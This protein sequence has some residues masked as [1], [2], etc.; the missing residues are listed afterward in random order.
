MEKT[1]KRKIDI[2]RILGVLFI[3][4]GLTIMAVDFGTRFLDRRSQQNE[5]QDF[6]NA[7]L[8]SDDDDFNVPSEGNDANRWGTI[9]ISKLGVN[10]IIAKSN[11]WSLL[12]R[13]VVAWENSPNP[14]S[15][16]NFAI[17]GHNGNC[18]SCVFRDFDQL[19]LGDTVE[20]NDKTN[21]YTYEITDIYIVEATDLSVL[22]DTPDAATL[23]LVT[24]KDQITNDPYRMIVKAILV[25]TQP[26][27]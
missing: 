4:V 14:P 12:N 1:K 17:A 2:F 6:L 22:D 19:E 16:G 15:N 27:A 23:T 5:L 21:N 3:L 25:D 7:P 18:A 8:L 10:H 26:N 20:L 13:Y 24:C 9:K 11:D